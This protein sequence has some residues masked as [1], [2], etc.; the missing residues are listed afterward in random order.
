MS[1]ALAAMVRRIA[2][3]SDRADKDR[4]KIGEKTLTKAV[5]ELLRHGG[6]TP[7]ERADV[8][9]GLIRHKVERAYRLDWQ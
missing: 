2:P 3:S 5:Q 8:A 7:A 4:P 6:G 1:D 9:T